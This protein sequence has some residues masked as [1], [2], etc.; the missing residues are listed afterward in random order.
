MDMMS[1]ES[2]HEHDGLHKHPNGFCCGNDQ[3]LQNYLYLPLLEEQETL[4]QVSSWYN[5]M[6]SG[7]EAQPRKPHWLRNFRDGH[8]QPVIQAESQYWA[9]LNTELQGT[10]IVEGLFV[11]WVLMLG[12]PA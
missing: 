9:S 7:H 1:A 11:S 5:W 12:G 6:D 4:A 10:P 2:E 3:V 8:Y